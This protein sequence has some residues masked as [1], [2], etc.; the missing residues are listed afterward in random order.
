MSWAKHMGQKISECQDA[1]IALKPDTSSQH[2]TFAQFPH[3][4]ALKEMLIM[5]SCRWE[6]PLISRRT[7]MSSSIRVV[8]TRH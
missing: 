4:D 1:A 6:K 5:N 3:N 8:I 7:N 2:S